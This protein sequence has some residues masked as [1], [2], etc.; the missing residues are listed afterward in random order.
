MRSPEGAPLQRYVEP[1]HNWLVVPEKDRFL[2][3]SRSVYLG[4]PMAALL[5]SASPSVLEIPELVLFGPSDG[6]LR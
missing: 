4:E 1:V 5:V 3:P 6:R 2:Q